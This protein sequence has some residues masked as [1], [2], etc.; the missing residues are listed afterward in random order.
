MLFCDLLTPS[1]PAFFFCHDKADMLLPQSLCNS[2]TWAPDL[3]SD[4]M[5]SSLRYHLLSKVYNEHQMHL[6]PSVSLA[7]QIHITLLYFLYTIQASFLYIAYI[8]NIWTACLSLKANT[9]ILY[10]YQEQSLA[11]WGYT[12]NMY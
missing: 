12:L 8:F 1:T 11:H 3:N 5:A 6:Q 7:V 9:C 4:C 2:S 10:A